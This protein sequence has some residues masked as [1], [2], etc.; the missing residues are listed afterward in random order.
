MYVYLNRGLILEQAI[1][2]LLHD[3]IDTL[4]LS[5]LYKN[6]HI[7]VTTEHPFA[8]LFEHEGKNAADTFPSIVV[9]TQ[10]DRKTPE[11]SEMQ[12]QT[13]EAVGIDAEDLEEITK[14]KET[15]VNKKGVKKTRDIPGLCTVVDS[16]KLAVV[17]SVIQSQ[18]LCYGW[19]FRTRRTDSIGIEIWATNNQL[20]NE[21]YE[22]V[23]LFV[24]GYLPTLLSAKYKSFDPSIFDKSIVGHRSNN[25]NFQFDVALSGSHIE[26]DVNYCIEQLVLNTE[27]ETLNTNIITEAENYVKDND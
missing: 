7:D 17:Q 15:Y 1:C 22:Q 12:I 4:N 21:L 10:E 27:L 20:K 6:Y 9:T 25:Y 14:T 13:V 3:Y 19:S 5:N 11:L 16:E 26:F 18:G 23:R 2:S 24:L 8:E